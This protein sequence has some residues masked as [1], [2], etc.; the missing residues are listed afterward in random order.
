MKKF[1]GTIKRGANDFNTLLSRG[2]LRILGDSEDVVSGIKNKYDFEKLFPPIFSYKRAVAMRATDAIEKITNDHSEYLEGH[3]DQVIE[4]TK[5][6]PNKEIKWHIAQIIP[7][8]PL[9]RDQAIKAFHHLNYWVSNPN[10]SKIVRVN[11]LQGMFELYRKAAD[12]GTA[13][14]L[15]TTLTSFER[16]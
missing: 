11:S 8:L 5:T 7:R 1:R 14:F 4:L 13:S 10:E 2:D 12:R 6:S 9:R 3:A 16:Q 15:R